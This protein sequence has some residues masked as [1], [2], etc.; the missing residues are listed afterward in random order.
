LKKKITTQ[1]VLAL[2]KREKKFRIEVDVLGHAIRG[3]LS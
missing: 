3:V 2:P 1:P